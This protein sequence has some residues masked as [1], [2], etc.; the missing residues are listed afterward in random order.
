[1]DRGAWWATVR[2]VARVGRG[3]GTN[4]SKIVRRLYCGENFTWGGEF[5]ALR[6]IALFVP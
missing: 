4:N 2:G 6:R 1:M 5:C 3:L